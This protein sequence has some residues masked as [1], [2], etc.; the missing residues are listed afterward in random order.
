MRVCCDDNAQSVLFFYH[1]LL[2]GR[3]PDS[4]GMEQG[5]DPDHGP[6]GGTGAS[7]AQGQAGRLEQMPKLSNK[8]VG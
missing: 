7:T 8:Q 4:R 6:G 2:L 5:L 1:F 3:R